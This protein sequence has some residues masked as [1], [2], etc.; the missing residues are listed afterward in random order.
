LYKQASTSKSHMRCSFVNGLFRERGWSGMVARYELIAGEL[1]GE[2]LSGTYP[3]GA[4]LPSE[5]ELAARFGAARGTVRQAVAVLAAEGLVG[6]R[7][8]ARRIVLGNA[9]SQSFAELHSFAQWARAAG[10]RYGGRV[11]S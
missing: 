5:S 4:Q 10:Y 7:Q 2:I 6:S 3:V 9:R 11:V 8:G 1:R